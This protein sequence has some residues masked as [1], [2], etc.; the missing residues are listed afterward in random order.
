LG[1]EP[2]GE[3]VKK[4]P[5]IEVARSYLKSIGSEVKG[6]S[7][8]AEPSPTITSERLVQNAEEEATPHHPLPSEVPE[9]RDEDVL[10]TQP[11]G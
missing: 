10:S 1:K 5:R 2:E 3:P 4:K 6:I 11:V 9:L 8:R 7:I